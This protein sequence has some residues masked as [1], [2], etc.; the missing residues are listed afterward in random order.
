VRTFLGVLIGLGLAT[1]AGC[2]RGR[3][4]GGSPDA[5]T[6]SAAPREGTQ[7]AGA[8]SGEAWERTKRVFHVP[9]GDSPVRGAPG[10]LVTIVEFANFACSTCAATEAIA[11]RAKYGDKVRLVWKNLLVGAQPA[12]EAAAEAALEVRAERGDDAFWDVHDRLFE[13]RAELASGT[14]ANVDAIVSLA[15]AAGADA[16]KVRRAIASQAHKEDL[17]AD[18]DLAEDFELK[19]VPELFVNGRHIQGTPSPQWLERTIDEELQKAQELLAKGVAPADL[20]ET[21]VKDG[22]GPWVPPSRA[23]PASLPPT[24]P[25]LGRPNARATVHVWNDYQCVLCDAVERTIAQIR[26]EHA[27]RVRVV[28]HDLPLP[29][30]KDALLA[31]EASREAYAQKGATAFWAIHDK[32]FEDPRPLTRADLDAFA[33]SLNLDLA[34]W[35]AAIDSG[36]HAGEI[37]ADARAAAELQIQETPAYLVVAGKSTRGYLVEYSHA[38]ERLPRAVERA[39][40]EAEQGEKD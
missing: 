14:Q 7:A 17:E 33:R 24:D 18:A 28:W 8:P 40:D 32:I 16:A 27:D 37:D 19:L 15:R 35:A 20:Y 5:S 10:A 13:R 29:R 6:A 3:V 25:P 21:L 31:A 30:H 11:S 39:L 4:Q 23:V 36:A 2:N 38:P 9:V 12:A 26:K 1:T 34:R 22:P